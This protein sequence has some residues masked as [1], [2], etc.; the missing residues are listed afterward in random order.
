MLS[1]PSQLLMRNKDTFAQG[2]GYWLT[3]PIATSLNN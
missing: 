3:Q 2:S 1:A